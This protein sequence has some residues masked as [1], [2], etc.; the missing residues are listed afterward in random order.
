MVQFGMRPVLPGFAGHVPQQMQV[1]F[2]QANV[3]H[4]APWHGH[5]PDG[6]YFLSPSSPLFKQLGAKFV[7][8][9]QNL[10]AESFSAPGKERARS[11]Y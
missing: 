4:L 8:G 11:F 1:N 2:P 6:T 9:L 5:F 3:T 7:T 10:G